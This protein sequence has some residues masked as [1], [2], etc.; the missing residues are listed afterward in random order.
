MNT[1]YIFSRWEEKHRKSYKLSGELAIAKSA[2]EGETKIKIWWA[3]WCW[4]LQ[5]PMFPKLL[6]LLVDFHSL[7]QLV[8]FD[9]KW[10]YFTPWGS[11]GEFSLLYL[12]ITGKQSK[13][14]KLLRLVYMGQQEMRLQITGKRFCRSNNFW[15]CY[16]QGHQNLSTCPKIMMNASKIPRS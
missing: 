7:V 11:S 15:R 14:T 13:L 6:A 5:K 10:L 4:D 9:T 3:F 16:S 2:S 8:K 1:V 12:K